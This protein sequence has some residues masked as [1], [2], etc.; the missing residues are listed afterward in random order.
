MK[1]LK[2][3]KKIELASQDQTSK[4]E[5]E[6]AI[7]LKALGHSEALVTDES[8]I[9]DFLPF[10]GSMDRK[11]AFDKFKKKMDKL[12]TEVEFHDY[13]IDVAKKLRESK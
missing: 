2:N 3:I 9:S 11:K 7:I 1:K 12:G 6:I 10:L 4:L 13:L 5:K 8:A